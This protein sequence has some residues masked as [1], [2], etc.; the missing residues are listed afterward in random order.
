MSSMTAGRDATHHLDYDIRKLLD[1]QADIQ[2]QLR[3]LIEAKHGF[4]AR[5]E[6]DML[7]YKVHVLEDLV[8]R[9]GSFFTTTASLGTAKDPGESKS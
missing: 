1:Q 6:L 4:D 3:A 7:R 2:A 9:Q 8:D 5:P